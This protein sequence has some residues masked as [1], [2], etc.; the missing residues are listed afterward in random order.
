LLLL[1]DDRVVLRDEVLELLR[2]EDLLL[3][4]LDDDSESS[5][6]EGDIELSVSVELQKN[7][8]VQGDGVIVMLVVLA[9]T[10]LEDSV[11]VVDVGFGG[12]R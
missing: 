4:L 11:S 5:V 7:V 3:L 2:V 6:L 10:P 8:E 12:P 1:A 9:K